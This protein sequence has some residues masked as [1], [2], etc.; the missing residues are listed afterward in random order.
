MNKLILYLLLTLTAVTFAGC[1]DENSD[2]PPYKVHPL[3][4]SEP[5][6]FTA[7]DFHGQVVATTAD[8]NEPCK[9]CHG[10]DLLGSG[11]VP[12][13]TACHDGIDGGHLAGFALPGVHGPRAIADFQL[14]K[15]CH[16][17]DYL[18]GIVGV[19]CDTCHDASTALQWP[20]DPNNLWLNNGS[21]N[22]HGTEANADMAL[23]AKCHGSDFRGGS[24]GVSC[25]TCHFN[26]NGSKIPPRFPSWVHENDHDFMSPSVEGP[27]CNACHTVSRTYNNGPGGCHDC[28]GDG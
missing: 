21:V 10:I 12:A 18:G 27:V 23:C 26:Q 13:C 25:F 11:D 6:N 1:S 4:W 24:T 16:G 3:A 28:H 2:I 15:M 7:V 5:T 17:D 22:F 19:S 14:C 20:H 9:Q 8:Y